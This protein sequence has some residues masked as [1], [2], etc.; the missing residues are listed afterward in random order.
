MAIKY[1]LRETITTCTSSPVKSPT[2]SVVSTSKVIDNSKLYL[3]NST[4]LLR[5]S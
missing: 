5:V 1:L 4:Q 3:E 2:T